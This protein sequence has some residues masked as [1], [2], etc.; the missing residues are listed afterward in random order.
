[1]GI[2]FPLFGISRPVS[3][4]RE[5]VDANRSGSLSPASRISAVEESFGFG[6]SRDFLSQ[7]ALKTVAHSSSNVGRINQIESSIVQATTNRGPHTDLSIRNRSSTR[8]SQLPFSPMDFELEADHDSDKELSE[9][10]RSQSRPVS[11][12]RQ[13]SRSVD[14]RLRAEK[15]PRLILPSTSSSDISDESPISLPNELSWLSDFVK[16]L[17]EGGSAT[18]RFAQKLI[19]EQIK[20]DGFAAR[21]QVSKKIITKLARQYSPYRGEGLRIRAEFMDP[22]LSQVSKLSSP[23]RVATLNAL[24]SISSEDFNIENIKS[25]VNQQLPEGTEE[26]DEQYIN[27]VLAEQAQAL[28]LKTGIL[29]REQG[30]IEL[31]R[32]Q[33]Q[34]TDTEGRGRKR[35]RTK[36]FSDDGSEQ[37]LMTFHW[38]GTERL[39]SPSLGS[40]R[41]LSP[42]TGFRRYHP[43]NF[44][45]NGAT[46]ESSMLSFTRKREVAGLSAVSEEERTYQQNLFK[47]A[48]NALKDF[49]EVESN[50]PDPRT[51]ALRAIKIE[52]E[53][54]PDLK[55][56]FE[57]SGEGKKGRAKAHAEQAFALTWFQREKSSEYDQAKEDYKKHSRLSFNQRRTIHRK[58]AR[59]AIKADE[60]GNV[61]FQEAGEGK[62]RLAKNRD[63]RACADNWYQLQP[64]AVLKSR[65]QVKSEQL[66]QT[67]L[68][69]S[70]KQEK[71]R[72]AAI[73]AILEDS[74]ESAKFRLLK[75]TATRTVQRTYALT[76]YQNQPAK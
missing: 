53:K 74:T 70:Q 30:F 55:K 47:T 35:V 43:K 1:M 5:R 66:D 16:K 69:I 37:T 68:T 29:N 65:Y 75:R 17:K 12:G 40:I 19:N 31:I 48:Y 9:A 60:R 28:S 4:T 62:L 15:R 57:A 46:P 52:I 49:L 71:L 23:R 27:K 20:K 44:N 61:L 10:E 67:S 63:Q 73:E 8:A 14:S 36:S 13:R 56:A 24:E 6:V 38:Q 41:A 72:D 45:A 21:F 34:R 26:V 7:Q 58:V 50:A 51:V 39:R 32:L 25:Q 22:H 33:D 54:N 3:L 59:E 42:K 76:W 2:N 11:R 64:S 18:T